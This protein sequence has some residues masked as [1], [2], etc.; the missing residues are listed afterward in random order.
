RA[1][2]RARIRVV[3]VGSATAA[4]VVTGET[5]V[6]LRSLGA[7]VGTADEGQVLRDVQAD[8]I[9]A[10]G[11]ALRGVAIA[12]AVHTGAA[13]TIRVV[14]ARLSGFFVAAGEIRRTVLL[15][16]TALRRRTAL[17]CR[18]RLRRAFDQRD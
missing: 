12:H 7:D 14:A 2:V 5:V 13:R 17:E 3:D 15:G 16:L 8:P 9:L 1:R 18:R 11:V 10:I 4:R 6:V